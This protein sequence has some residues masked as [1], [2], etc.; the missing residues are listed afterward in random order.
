M[1][2]G[3]CLVVV[4][5][6]GCG[7][8]TPIGRFLHTVSEV[9]DVLEWL[10]PLLFAIVFLGGGLLSVIKTLRAPTSH[11]RAWAKVLGFINVVVGAFFVISMLSDPPRSHVEQSAPAGVEEVFVDGQIQTR[12]I[13][14]THEAPGPVKTGQ[15]VILLGIGFGTAVLGGAGIWVARKSPA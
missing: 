9:A 4:V 6:S 8:N 5:C 14:E 12:Q 11:S 10:C 3:L 2:T 7:R 15:L 1:R 13:T